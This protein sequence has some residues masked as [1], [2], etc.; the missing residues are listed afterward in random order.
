MTIIKNKR[1]ICF[2][3][4]LNI[5]SMLI[6]C[7]NISNIQNNPLNFRPKPTYTFLDYNTDLKYMI[8]YTMSDKFFFSLCGSGK[9][10]GK[11]VINDNFEDIYVNIQKETIDVYTFDD[12]YLFSAN[13]YINTL[14]E[15]YLTITKT[16]VNTMTVGEKIPLSWDEFFNLGM[17]D[18]EYNF[19]SGEE[20]R[21]TEMYSGNSPVISKDFP[22][23]L[24]GDYSADYRGR[25][26]LG[27]KVLKECN[28]KY[29][30]IK[31]SDNCIMP[32]DKPVN[33]SKIYMYNS[34]SYRVMTDLGIMLFDDEEYGIDNRQSLAYTKNE[35]AVEIYYMYDDN[36]I[37]AG[38]ITYYPQYDALYFLNVD[39]YRY[40]LTT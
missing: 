2:V 22:N 15:F 21:I 29:N 7:T 33:I 12:E 4:I 28:T 39:G 9:G 32:D 1:I 6:G 38:V 26:A 34:G 5:I 10:Y 27:N 14:D 35:P 30:N 19:N 20:W 3:I 31:I 36:N 11:M 18:N 24:R 23:K 37:F 40:K 25:C 13:Y 17:A 8:F 16:N